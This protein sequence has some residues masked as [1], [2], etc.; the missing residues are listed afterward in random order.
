MQVANAPYQS[1][2]AFE[3]MF[4]C[5]PKA[6]YYGYKSW[7]GKWKAFPAS[8]DFT[9]TPFQTSSPVKSAI[10]HVPSPPKTTTPS[11]PTPANLKSTTSST[12]L[13]SETSS[14]I[15]ASL[16]LSSTCST[17]IRL[18]ETSPAA[19]ST[20]PSSLLSLTTAGTPPSRERFVVRSS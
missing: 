15:R 5:D 4:V 3:D 10:Q 14:S 2:H 9:N 6:K 19:Q 18:P 20:K 11:S 1:S 8:P 13:S 7:D 12:T 16:T 17:M